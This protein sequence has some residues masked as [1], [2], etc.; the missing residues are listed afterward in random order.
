MVGWL[1]GWLVGHPCGELVALLAHLFHC[2]LGVWLFVRLAGWLVGGL[3]GLL[4]CCLLGWVFGLVGHLLQVPP[5]LGL[6]CVGRSMSQLLV[7]VSC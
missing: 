1:V 6:W 4:L 3:L 2:C 5:N 7:V